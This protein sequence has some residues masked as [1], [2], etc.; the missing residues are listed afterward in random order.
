M[1][2]CLYRSPQGTR[3]T[4]SE[5]RSSLRGAEV[6]GGTEEDKDCDNDDDDEEENEDEDEGARGVGAGADQSDSRQMGHSA[7]REAG[8]PSIV[9]PSSSSF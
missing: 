5:P 8:E 3:R 2:L 4:A 6:G 7:E 9:Q 1:C